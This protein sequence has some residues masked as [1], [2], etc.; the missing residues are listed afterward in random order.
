MLSMSGNRC[1]LMALRRFSWG[2]WPATNVKEELEQ[3]RRFWELERLRERILEYETLSEEERAIHKAHEEAVRRGHFTY[4]DPA[5]GG[6]VE[7]RYKHF[8]TGLCC[9]YACRHCTFN[10][11]NVPKY[12]KA[13]KTFNS[14]FWVECSDGPQ[15]KEPAL[16][17]NKFSLRRLD[18]KEDVVSSSSIP[19]TPPLDP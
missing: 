19:E 15:V 9:G 3:R 13:S 5:G 7:T 10:F 18:R 8:L 12:L 17:L 14:S 4:E 2:S 16:N 1:Q 6:T 11:Y